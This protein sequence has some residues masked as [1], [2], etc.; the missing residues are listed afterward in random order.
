MIIFDFDNEAVDIKLPEKQIASINIS[1]VSG[2][3]TG[4]VIF[5]DGEIVSFDASGCRLMN[6]Y[7]GSYSVAGENIQK[8]LDFKPTGKGTASYERQDLFSGLMEDDE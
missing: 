2:D 7:D 1:V 3:E 6:F 4:N 5:K 8:W